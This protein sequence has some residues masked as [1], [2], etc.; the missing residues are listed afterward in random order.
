[1]DWTQA[2]TIIVSLGGI[3]VW[4]AHKFDRD[5]DRIDRNM[6]THA[7]RMDQFNARCDQMYQ[8]FIDLLK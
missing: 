4:F 1:M 8:M 3:M 7:Q 2:I 5:V 6:E